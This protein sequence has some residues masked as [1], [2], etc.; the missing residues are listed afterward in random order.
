QGLIVLVAFLLLRRGW[1]IVSLIAGYFAG[2]GVVNVAL[3]LLIRRR[4]RQRLFDGSK[5]AAKELATLL[6]VSGSILG[7][8]ILTVFLGPFNKWMIAATL[9]VS[10]V[11]I[12]EIA[13]GA[14]MQVRNV[15]EFGLR[16]LVPEISRVNA[17]G[18]VDARERIRSVFHNCLL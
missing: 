4:Y 13:F 15:F 9:G 5:L 14:S 2:R 6:R 16:S 8:T 1:G 11:P 17:I 18:S 7:G 3:I 12:Y 10:E